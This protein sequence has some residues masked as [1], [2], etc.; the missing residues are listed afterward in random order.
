MGEDKNT[1]QKRGEKDKGLLNE[2]G[3]RAIRAKLGLSQREFSVLLGLGEIS[4]ARYE[5][6]A[7]QSKTID[8]LIK[9]AENDPLFLYERYLENKRSLPLDARKRILSL[10]K[11]M[12]A[13][14]EAKKAAKKRELAFL[15]LPYLDE[16]SFTGDTSLSLSAISSLIALGKE[17]NGS[18][19]RNILNKYLFYCDFLS[20][21]RLG[22][23]ITGLVYK[24][25]DDGVEPRFLDEILS[26]PAF[27]RSWKVV[28]SK[29]GTSYLAERVASKDKVKLEQEEKDIGKEVKERLLS[30]SER[31]LSLYALKEKPLKKLKKGQII[32]YSLSSLLSV[33]K[34]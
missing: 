10:I 13:G 5:N 33:A 18:M 25:V 22:K 8:N 24:K 27:K 16:I 34:W 9:S 12:S 31:E 11:T 19:S 14:D 21:L 29:N 28:F 4:I 17:K 26:Y 15:M 1:L 23:G 20:F 30:L 6:K 32:D 3:I 7:N 2:E